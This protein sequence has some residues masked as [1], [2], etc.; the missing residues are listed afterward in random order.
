MANVTALEQYLKSLIS[1]ERSS[2]Q[3]GL[4]GLPQAIGPGRVKT[5]I[6]TSTPV[7]GQSDTTT[8]Y[9]IQVEG[10]YPKPSPIQGMPPTP[11][12]MILPMTFS[13]DDLVWVSEG[14]VDEEGN[15]IVI[16][17]G[18]PSKGPA[19]PANGT[20]GLIIGQ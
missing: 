20:G 4:R 12:P 6:V 14:P 2:I 8:I 19:R 5:S 17:M 1:L 7:N 16:E 9:T 18:R 11:V 13:G 3:V 15:P 10:I